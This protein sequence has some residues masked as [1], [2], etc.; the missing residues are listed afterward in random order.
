MKPF[1]NIKLA[2]VQ[3]STLSQIPP[4]CEGR[5]VSIVRDKSAC[6]FVAVPESQVNLT[7]V[8][9]LWYWLDMWSILR[10]A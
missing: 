4:N 10:R 6:Y 9:D 3:R 8:G 1:S 5:N 7:S 2:P